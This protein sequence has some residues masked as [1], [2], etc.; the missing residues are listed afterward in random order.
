MSEHEYSPTDEPRSE[1]KRDKARRAVGMMCGFVDEARDAA[2]TLVPLPVVEHLAQSQRHALAAV[3]RLV[4]MQA[5][6]TDS[7]VKRAR[8]IHRKRAEPPVDAP[9][10]DADP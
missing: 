3:S 10:Q 5:D 6:R 1:R 4:E 2:L 9:P 8:E 7:A